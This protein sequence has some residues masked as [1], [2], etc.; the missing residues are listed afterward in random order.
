MENNEAV[1]SEKGFSGS[2][3]K[4]IAIV[5][6]LIDHIGAVIM[7]RYM[8]YAGIN[9]VIMSGDPSV[10]MPQYGKFYFSYLIIRCIGRMGFPLFGFL[11]I[12]GFTHTSNK[13]KYA[14]RLALFALVS[15]IPF[16]LAVRNDWNDISYQN[17]FFT[18]LLA[19]LALWW[20]EYV[21]TKEVKKLI[22][23]L[24]LVVTALLGGYWVTSKFIDL[25][26]DSE[27]KIVAM[28]IIVSVCAVIILLAFFRYGTL[29]GIEAVWKV[30]VATAGV[31]VLMMAAELLRTDYAGLGVLAIVAGYV[32]KN[33]KKKS[34][35]AE[36]IV[37]S[38][39]NFIEI[40]AI[41]ALPFVKRYNGKKGLN[42][43]YVFY[44]FYPAHLLILHLISWA[45]GY[46]SGPFGI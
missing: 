28:L 5:S 15:E 25:F 45:L 35:I 29:M 32:Y 38:V 44:V 2:T 24:C 17:V 20:C 11:L 39:F 46:I 7:E 34:F 31:V 23:N 43:K 1:V 10:W 9:E 21:W 37:L 26:A 19:F 18:L 41:A 13:K 12:E 14:I 8:I 33:N 3:I 22:G 27:N 36:W 16:N 30:S 40:F 4:I 42:L 6:M